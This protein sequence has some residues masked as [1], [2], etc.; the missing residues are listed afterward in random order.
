MSY[1]WLLL[2]YDGNIESMHPR[3]YGLKN[4][5]HVLSGPLQRKFVLPWAMV[6]E[7]LRMI[8]LC[9]RRQQIVQTRTS[10]KTIGERS[11]KK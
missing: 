5:K 6:K 10:Q 8:A 1:L 7:D 2:C 4:P 11:P 9:K 3:P